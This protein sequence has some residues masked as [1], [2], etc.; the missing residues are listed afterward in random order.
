MTE[1]KA[2]GGDGRS[3]SSNE[4]LQQTGR[5]VLYLPL[6]DIS[7]WPLNTILPLC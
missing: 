6:F 4:D 2:F 7:V 1:R 3:D 5:V